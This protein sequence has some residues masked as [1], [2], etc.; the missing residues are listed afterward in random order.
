M[1]KQSFSD[2]LLFGMWP[3]LAALVLILAGI[4]SIWFGINVVGTTIEHFT[5]ERQESK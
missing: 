4:G 1:S 5:P 3:A 2:R